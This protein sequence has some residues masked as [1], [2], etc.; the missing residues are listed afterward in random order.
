VWAWPVRDTL[1]MTTVM[2]CTDGS[3]LALDALRQGL[4]LLAPADRLVLVTVAPGVDPSLVTGTGFAGGVMSIDDKEALL[5]R[6]RQEAQEILDETVTELGLDPAS[7]PET[8]VLVGDPGH[9]ICEL[10]TF[11]PADVVV[12]GTHG[13]SGIKRAMMGSTSDHV[14]RHAAC[15]V[16]VQ[17]RADT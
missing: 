9:E 4:A 1:D 2:L 3:D 5:E 12:I 17:G 13:R 10:A 16:L 7:A 8:M 15:P 6:E 14:V 11:L